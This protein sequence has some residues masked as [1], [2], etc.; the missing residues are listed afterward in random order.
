MNRI[1]LLIV[2]CWGPAVPAEAEDAMVSSLRPGELREFE[3]QSPEIQE[4]LSYA[5]GLTERG[6]AYRFGSGDPRLGGMDC[7][8]TVWH[9]LRH[10][11]YAAPRSSNEIFLWLENAG[12]LRRVRDQRKVDDP[13]FAS[14]RPGDLLF[15][16]G[17]YAVGKRNPPTSHVMIY[18]GRLKE[19]GRPVMVGASSGRRFAGKVRHGVSVFDFVLPGPGADSSF[20]GFGSVPGLEERPEPGGLRRLEAILSRWKTP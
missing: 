3:Q 17:T 12:N 6:L 8:G 7:S 13:V 10:L 19:D 16:E 14:L 18:L 2:F 20:V 4:L 1:L 9:I 5:L 11:G 15:W